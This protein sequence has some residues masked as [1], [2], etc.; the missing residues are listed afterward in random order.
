[1]ITT[2]IPYLVMN[3][4]AS[5][6]IDFY[7]EALNAEV[8]FVQTFGEMPHDTPL[9]EESKSLIGHATIKV[10]QTDLM[11]SDAFPGMPHQI[12]TQVTICLCTSDVSTSKQALAALEQGGQVGMP[13]TET[14]FSPGYAI[15][16][17]KFGV[18]WQIYTEGQH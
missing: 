6:A 4:N 15:V 11:L 13:L 14:H 8:M 3:G 17:D 9:T 18:T 2:L 5:E 16:T 12:G 10:G 1:M 7:K